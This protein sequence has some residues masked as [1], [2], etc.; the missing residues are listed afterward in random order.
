MQHLGGQWV[1]SVSQNFLMLHLVMYRQL[2]TDPRPGSPRHVH[3]CE[4]HNEC[5]RSTRNLE[6]AQA[7]HSK[8]AP[9]PSCNGVRISSS[10]DLHDKAI[11]VSFV[12]FKQEVFQ[13]MLR[14]LD[15]LD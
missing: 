14:R 10:L 13:N 1:G 15:Q 11:V 3:F 9:V 4:S 7:F 2:E 12:N 8:S 5:V 6:I